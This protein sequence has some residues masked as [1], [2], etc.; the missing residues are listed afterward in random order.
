MASVTQGEQASRDAE[1]RRFGEER[2]LPEETINDLQRFLR[3]AG[4]ATDP[5][6]NIPTHLKYTVFPIIALRRT[7]DCPSGA[8]AGDPKVQ[9]AR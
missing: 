1:A 4:E 2:A 3:Q 6:C 9:G 7:D 5:R 8:V